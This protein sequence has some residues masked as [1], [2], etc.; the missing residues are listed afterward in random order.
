MGWLK[1]LEYLK[2]KMITYIYERHYRTVTQKLTTISYVHCTT[3][4]QTELR[5]WSPWNTHSPTSSPTYVIQS[6]IK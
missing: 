6:Q 1:L 3:L 5:V 4:W 2:M